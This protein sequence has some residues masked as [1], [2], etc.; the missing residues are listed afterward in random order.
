VI[1]ASFEY[2]RAASL[3]DA[4]TALAGDEGTKVL[5]GG[6]SLIPMMKFRLAQPSRLIDIGHLNELK[7]IAEYRRGARI[8]ALTTYREILESE[9]LRERFPILAEVTEGIGDVQVR[10]R[11]TLGG[12]IAHADPASDMPAVM[13]AIDASFVL[14]A[15]KGK[16][17]VPAREFFQGAF[18]T[19]LAPDELVMEIIL[20]PLPRG[21][22]TAYVAFN[23]AASGYALV[24]AAAIVA[25]SRKTVN[26]AVVTLTG[27]TEP[28]RMVKAAE[29]LVG[30]KG[31]AD[32][33]ARVAAAA[34]E[35]LEIQGDVHAPAPYRRHLVT[36]ATR[37]ALT[38][39]L[40][41]AK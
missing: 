35:G 15:K 6:H 40:E 24:A 26:H 18:S 16:R 38:K 37:D 9:L 31:D 33:V 23:Q 19:A 4:L 41:R 17:V 1:P 29:Q 7:G 22:G 2:T 14:R 13:L 21:A 20:P 10:N 32:T 30:T 25:R 34:P 8:G 39:A 11:G 28:A 36:V 27:L 12:G 5:A 3:R